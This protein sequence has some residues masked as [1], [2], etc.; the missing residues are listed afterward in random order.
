MTTEL[1]WLNGSVSLLADARIPIEE[2]GHQF[3]DG[4]Y[5]VVRIYNG[6][7][8]TLNEHLDR[9]ERSAKDLLI[10]L[11]ISKSQLATDVRNLIAKSNMTEGM[12]Y[13]Q[14]SRGCAP[15][16]HR[17]PANCKATLFF[18]NR[19]LPPV[20][21]P[22]QAQGIKLLTLPDE[23]W[24]RCWI[25]A[26]ALLPNVLAKNQAIAQGADE[27]VFIEN[28][29]YSECSTSNFYLIKNGRMITHASGPKVLP[30]ITRQVLL[31]IARELGIS[32]EERAAKEE[33]ARTAD[34]MFITSTTR[35]VA[36][37]SHLDGKQIGSG[38]C[39]ALTLKLHQAL[40]E[41]IRRDTCMAQASSPSRATAL[42]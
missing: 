36:W 15:R 32:V 30:G 8:F 26:I 35:E 20:P 23:R 25:K 12:I 18:Y 41:R 1:I 5:E 4:V 16:D 31:P 39:G 10:S 27:A 37:V 38:V 13:M 7:P 24:K 28:G 21:A 34:E 22:G 6:Q 3:A 14:L 2:R 11:P 17:F 29:L 19:D 33:E 42:A 9:L 40:Q